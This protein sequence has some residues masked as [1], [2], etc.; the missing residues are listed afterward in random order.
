MGE[1]DPA[2]GQR[3]LAL[4]Q[5]VELLTGANPI[6]GSAPGQ[7]AVDLDPGDGAVETFVVVLLGLGE[8]SR[9]CRE[10][11]K[12]YIDQ[13]AVL[14]QFRAELGPRRFTPTPHCHEESIR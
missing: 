10:L 8:F 12:D 6:P 11:E 1:T 13:A 3:N 4:A 5:P 7:V 14:D 2:L 9:D